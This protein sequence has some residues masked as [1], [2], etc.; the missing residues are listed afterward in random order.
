[1]PSL[2]TD[3]KNVAGLN[4]LMGS[5]PSLLDNLFSNVI[6][7][8]TNKNKQDVARYVVLRI[9]PLVFI[10]KSHGKQEVDVR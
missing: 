1:M 3:T 5:Q 7:M 10:C 9:P 8:K 6:Q 2:G 4:R